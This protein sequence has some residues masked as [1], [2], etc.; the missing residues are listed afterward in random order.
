LPAQSIFEREGTFTSGERRVQRFYPAQGVI[1]HSLPEWQMF[2][3]IRKALNGSALPRLA[4]AIMQEITQA[5]PTYAEMSYPNLA[6]VERQFPDVG[7]TD[8]YYGGTAYDNKGGLGV[9]WASSAEVGYVTPYYV[10]AKKSTHKGLLVVPIT[11]LYDK[12]MLFRHSVMMRHRIGDAYAVIH[13][14]DAKGIV[15]GATITVKAGNHSYEVQAVVSANAPKGVV[16]LPKRMTSQPSLFT[17]TEGTIS[18]VAE[19]VKG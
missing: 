16:L 11:R 10:K 18:A 2:S 7:G 12:G 8:L 15:D 5:I 4:A 3:R 14:D 1:G 13:P 6:K 9:Q 17:P 19:P